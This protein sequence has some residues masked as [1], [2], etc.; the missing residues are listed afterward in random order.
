M[1][2]ASLL[3][4]DGFIAGAGL[5]LTD[6]GFRYGMSVFETVAIR[7]SAPLL[8]EAHLLKLARTAIVARFRPPPNWEEATRGLLLHPQISEGVARIYI[9]A[10]DNGRSESRV[11]VLL[12]EM[13]IPTNLSKM[14][15]VTAEFT[16]MIPFGK[17]GNYWPH[18]LARPGEGVEAILCRPDGILLGGAMSNLFLIIED[19]LFTPRQA[20]RRGIMRSWIN[21]QEA[22]LTRSDLGRATS[23]FL[24]NSRMG[25]CAL[26]SIDGLPLATDPL[27]EALWQ[28]YRAEVLR[29]A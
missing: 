29:A 22:D 15:G 13:P 16:P 6:R 23:A 1:T 3:G 4:P 8:L 21:G 28:R 9:T 7:E 18:F 19:A 27:V 25:I 20:I 24:T 12:E 14:P 5:P 2:H 11:A 26:T 10:G 17:T